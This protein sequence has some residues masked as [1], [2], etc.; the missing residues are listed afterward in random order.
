[1]YQQKSQT[2][3]E[4][5]KNKKKL[6][7]FLLFLTLSILFWMLIKLS[8]NYIVDVEFDLVYT[9]IPQNKLLQNEPSTKL[10]LTVNTI[11]FK[12]LKYSFKTKRLNYS[13]ADLKRN[14]GSLYYS[15]TKP[16][17]NYLQAQLTAE[18]KVLKIE[19]DTLFFDLGVKKSKV[20]PIVSSA[21]LKFKKG[22]NLVKKYSLHPEVV[23][24]SGPTKFIDSISEI[25]T[26]EL[27]I[28]DIS[29]SFETELQ[30]VTPNNSVS[31]STN[32]ILIKG[33]VEKIT[34]GSFNVNYKII[35]LPENYFIS[36]YP[37]EI[38]VVYQV[39]L[40]DYNKISENSFEVICD[41]K[42]TEIN[43]LDY[44]IPKIIEK[45]DILFDVKVVPNKIEFLIKK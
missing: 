1:M 41:Y 32:K 9:E 18:T 20:I 34:E 27:E 33:E 13:L 22:Y 2:R 5:L 31:L 39:S 14:K 24:V 11:G 42:E 29:N 6:R 12:L 40:K 38:K 7:I 10:K 19:P 17:L 23:T 15:I 16:K 4:S 8:K 30:L 44:L 25:K 37:K 45:P 26:E 35:N 3:I 43:N 36:S 28:L 21:N